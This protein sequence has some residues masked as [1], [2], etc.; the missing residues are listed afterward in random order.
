MFPFALLV[1]LGYAVKSVE[2]D[3]SVSVLAQKKL[4]P[5]RVKNE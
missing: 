2:V 4:T 1:I 5:K 3:N